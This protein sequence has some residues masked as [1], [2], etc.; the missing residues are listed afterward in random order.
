M[1]YV[2]KWARGEGAPT[3]L[4]A[5]T[6]MRNAAEEAENARRADHPSPSMADH[7]LGGAQVHLNVSTAG[8]GLF[9]PATP[10]AGNAGGN[11]A[12]IAAGSATGTGA[13]AVFPGGA[14]GGGG[15]TTGLA[16]VA[17][18]E[19]RSIAGA[20][21]PLFD[22]NDGYAAHVSGRGYPNSAFH[23]VPMAGAYGTTGAAAG[24]GGIGGG[25]GGASAAWNAVSGT[26]SR[27]SSAILGGG[28][29]MASSDGGARRIGIT[30]MPG[31]GFDSRASS[32]REGAVWP[33]TTVS[34]AFP[35][36]VSDR[37]TCGKVLV[38]VFDG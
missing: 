8:S 35:Q 31:A 6:A 29:R 20:L 9:V 27:L 25:G 32:I 30:E 24:A 22:A 3:A 2:K 12:G 34:A 4:A 17:G 13:A 38:R 14:A 37:E 33:I 36:C 7:S 18:A 15:A 5:R 21:D 10:G 23:G 11:A 28:G 19:P 26:V 1:E 16:G